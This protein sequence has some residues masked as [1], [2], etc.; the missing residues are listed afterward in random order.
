M[1]VIMPD[2]FDKLNERQIKYV[3]NRVAGKTQEDAYLEAGYDAK[4][5][6]SAKAA[7]SQ[8]EK[9]D[10]IRQAIQEIDE[11]DLTEP[12]RKMG[13]IRISEYVKKAVDVLN[14]IQSGDFDDPNKA[15][16]MKE[17]AIEVLDRAGIMPKKAKTEEGQLNFNFD[18]SDSDVREIEAEYAE[19]EDE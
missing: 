2:I 11:G 18:L 14:K 15:R 10:K 12:N 13:E 7:A 16:V 4:P 9:K 6:N 5:G 3:Q 19:L 8:L 1:V 17:S